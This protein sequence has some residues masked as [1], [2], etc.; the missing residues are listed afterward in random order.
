MSASSLLIIISS[1]PY[2]GTDRVWNALRLAETAVSSGT[3]T[4]VFLI[5][6]GV[7]TGRPAAAPPDVEYN[8][9]AILT[10][11]VDKGVS[12]RYCKT[13]IDRCGVGAGEMAPPLEVGSMK[14]LHQ[15]IIESDRVV[16]F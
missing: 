5:N 13:C 12:V 10:E 2:A 1:P 15:W 6:D 8:L 16:T 11:L 7:D 4:R 3:A 14:G 9:C